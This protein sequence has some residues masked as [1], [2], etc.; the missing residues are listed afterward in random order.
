MKGKDSQS[1]SI[2]H[3]PHNHHCPH[4]HKQVTFHGQS[5]LNQKIYKW[6]DI[7]A[8][9]NPS[10]TPINPT[11]PTHIKEEIKVKIIEGDNSLD[12]DHIVERGIIID[13]LIDK[14]SEKITLLK[15]NEIIIEERMIIITNVNQD[16][17]QDQEIWKRKY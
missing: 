4:S 12:K 15:T 8:T 9:S 10:N 5:E 16:H 1:N 11:F 6:S 14:I 2:P 13:H 3:I 7:M 17:H